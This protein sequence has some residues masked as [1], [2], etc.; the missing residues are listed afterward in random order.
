M[1]SFCPERTYF[2]PEFFPSAFLLLMQG[3][4]NALID[5][6]SVCVNMTF[7]ANADW[8]LMKLQI[9]ILVCFSEGHIFFCLPQ[10]LGT[11]PG[12]TGSDFH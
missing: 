9:V 1:K 12:V 10:D 4:K 11:I 7:S 2:H 3:R 5:S 6:N 8:S